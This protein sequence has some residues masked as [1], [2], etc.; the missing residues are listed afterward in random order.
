MQLG[1]SSLYILNTG[2]YYYLVTNSTAKYTTFDNIM[3]GLKIIPS[4]YKD[5]LKLNILDYQD[6]LRKMLLALPFSEV[7]KI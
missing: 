3:K 1:H 7:V 5:Y 2:W 6:L 4:C